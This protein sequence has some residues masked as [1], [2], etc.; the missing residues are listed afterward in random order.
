MNIQIQQLIF[1]KSENELTTIVRSSKFGIIVDINGK[2]V[3]LDPKRF[4]HHSDF[5]FISHA[6]TDH[7]CK[8]TSTTEN[9]RKILVSKATSLIAQARGYRLND[10]TEICDGF[11]LINTGHILGSRGLLIGNELYYTGDISIRERS[12]MKPADI[13]SA[14]TL[15][16]ESTF[17]RP[18]YVFPNL[19]EIIHKT[20]GIISE[21]YN[22]GVPVL[23][24]GYPV[25]KAQL[26]AALF[27]H[28][29]PIFVHDSIDKMNSVYMKLGINLKDMTTHSVAEKKGLLA[30]NKPWLMIAPLNAARSNFVKLMKQRYGAVTIGFS[31][32]AIDRRYKFMMDLDYTMPMSDHCDFPELVKV[33]RACNPKKIYTFHG[34]SD[35][36][37]ASLRKIGFDAESLVGTNGQKSQQ[38]PAK[39]QVPSSMPDEYT[40][41]LDHFFS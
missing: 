38:Q 33:V 14:H 23:L 20:N 13:P 26:L 15:I 18:E 34:F 22:L 32:W 24:M 19:V 8:K 17:G 12:F 3:S 25:G 35:E 4:N 30:K 27:G 7:L 41:R 36:F 37:A 9:N 28:W 40:L 21:M 29:D 16:I 2:T 10:V 1:R 6:H 39:K 31:G 11:Q 5:T